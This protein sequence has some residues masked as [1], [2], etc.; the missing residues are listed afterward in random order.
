M[1]SYPNQLTAA[2][3]GVESYSG[4]LAAAL[5]ATKKASGSNGIGN[6]DVVSVLDW[7]NTPA[8]SDTVR[9]VPGDMT[10]SGEDITLEP[11]QLY[12]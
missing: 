11:G 2:K 5:K 1:Q 4:L 9:V 7:F 8:Y 12:T 6:T 3:R 10:F